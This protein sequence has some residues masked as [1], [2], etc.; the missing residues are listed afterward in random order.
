ML[1][2]L[3]QTHAQHSPCHGIQRRFVAF[4]M[5]GTAAV[6][7]GFAFFEGFGGRGGFQFVE[8]AHLRAVFYRA[9]V[10]R[11]GSVT[12]EGFF[13]DFPHRVYIVADRV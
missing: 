11:V 10:V 9:V 2:N 8:R 1:C 12:F 7:E 3:F 6:G 5:V 4:K 13:L